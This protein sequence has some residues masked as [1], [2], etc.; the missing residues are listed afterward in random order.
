[1]CFNDTMMHKTFRKKEM[2][3]CQLIFHQ[4]TKLK[5]QH[6]LIILHFTTCEQL[7]LTHFDAKTVKHISGSQR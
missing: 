4:Q 3:A 1:M 6:I 7:L 2:S 5:K